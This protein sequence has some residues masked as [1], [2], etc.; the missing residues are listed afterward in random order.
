MVPVYITL[1]CLENIEL[2]FANRLTDMGVPGLCLIYSYI[3]GKVLQGIF[4]NA[5]VFA[6]GVCGLGVHT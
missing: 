3:H 5:P 1:K 2:L 4:Y 6:S